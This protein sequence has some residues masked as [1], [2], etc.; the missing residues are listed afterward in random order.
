MEWVQRLNEAIKFIET[1]LLEEIDAELIAQNI[2]ISPY[3]FQRIF[4]LLT[5]IS[6]GEYI[7]NRRLSSAAQELIQSQDKLIDIAYKYGYETP[8]SFSKAFTR[9]HGVT[10]L[11]VKREG[12]R[13]KVYTPLVIKIKLEGGC[14][15]DYKIEKRE[16]FK[17]LA[18]TRTFSQDTSTIEIPKFWGEFMAKGYNDTV[19]GT[20][21]ICHSVKE[22]RFKY[23]IAD[24]IKNEGVCPENFEIIEIPS[25]TWAMFTC[26]GAMPNAIQDM[27]KRVYSEWLPS[28]DY[29]MVPGYDIEM[30]TAG[31]VTKDDYI[32]EIW[33]PVQ[34][35]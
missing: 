7:R 21:G 17:V 5:G 34:P 22:G 9:F 35:K 19:C 13:V 8:E 32:S 16:A 11:S 31:D 4:S 27:W 24:P 2:Y 18:M 30:Y 28:A 25:L 14:F 20:F 10:P 12:A 3:H 29:E 15:M 1:H 23:S 26:V 6:L 33:I